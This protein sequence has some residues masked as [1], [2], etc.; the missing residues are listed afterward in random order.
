MHSWNTFGAKMNHEQTQI[1][2]F[3]IAR[4]WG[5]HHLPPYSILYAYPQALHPN[6]ILLW[7]SQV[8][9]FKILE[10]G[11]LATL[12]AHNVLCTPSIEMKSE[13]KL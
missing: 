6:V 11:I 5:N 2:R 8:V 10:M 4:T 9:S 1:T 13:A 3:I 12:E 7:D